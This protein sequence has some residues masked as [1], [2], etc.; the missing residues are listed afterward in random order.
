M[1]KRLLRRPGTY[2]TSSNI[3]VSAVFPCM[4]GVYHT[5][6]FPV[7]QTTSLL[8]SEMGTFTATMLRIQLRCGVIC[9][10]APESG[11]QE[12]SAGTRRERRAGGL[13]MWATC[14]SM[15]FSS[16]GVVAAGADAP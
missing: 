16:A 7:A 1:E 8:A 3:K 2:S 12:K 13:A 5:S 10:V 11:F 9:E 14:A 6:P 4:T 15:A